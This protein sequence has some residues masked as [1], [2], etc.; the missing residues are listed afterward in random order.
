MK[1]LFGPAALLG[2]WSRPCP[3]KEE[4]YSKK[5]SLPPPSSPFSHFPP[6]YGFIRLWLFNDTT[7]FPA[8]LL[9]EWTPGDLIIYGRTYN[10]FRYGTGTFWPLG[11]GCAG[12][13]RQFDCLPLTT[14][15][16]RHVPKET[17]PPAG[18]LGWELDVCMYPVRKG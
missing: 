10:A 8:Q 13:P 16:M 18:R 6:S 17:P 11:I 14:H 5:S 7:I 15:C 3:A 12:Q 1:R 2:T 9:G 4:G